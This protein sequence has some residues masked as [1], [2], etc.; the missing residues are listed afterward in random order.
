M[1]FYPTGVTEGERGG[2]GEEREGERGTLGLF[3]VCVKKKKVSFAFSLFLKIHQLT[4]RIR[5]L[6]ILTSKYTKSKS[7][8]L[9]MLSQS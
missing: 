3:Y 5:K 1:N 9:E 7:Q 8:R 6:P 4:W 2:G